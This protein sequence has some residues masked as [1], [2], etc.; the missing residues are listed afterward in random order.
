MLRHQCPKFYKHALLLVILWLAC[1][2][3]GSASVRIIKGTITDFDSHQ[4]VAAATVQLTGTGLA[5]VANDQGQYR[6][7]INS[8][9]GEL[10]VSHVAY[11]SERRPLKFVDSIT[12]LNFELHSAVIELS[13]QVVTPRNYNAAQRIILAAIKRKKE[14]LSNLQCYSVDS[15]TRLVAREMQKPDSIN[16]MFITET[17]ASTYFRKPNSP[18]QVIR[19]RRE[20]ANF[21][22]DLNTIA[23]GAL[24]SLSRDRIELEGN[25]IVTPT[26]EDALDH[27][28]FYLI[29]SVMRDN[30]RVFELEIEPRNQAEPLFVGK[31]SVI[32]STYDVVQLDAGINKGFRSVMIRDMRYCV[33]YAQVDSEN[34]M[35]V[36]VRNS[37]HLRPSLLIPM[38]LS[39]SLVASLYN[40]SVN[41]P[42]S[43]GI[44]DEYALKVE[45]DADK[46]DTIRWNS[47]QSIPLSMEEAT[48]Y[49]RI[50][51]ISHVPPSVPEYLL[52]G[53]LRVGIAAAIYGDIF[54]F[55]RVEGA[56]LGFGTTLTKEAKAADIR[57]KSGYAFAANRWEHEYGVS[58]RL[59]RRHKVWAGA[60]YS[61]QYVSRPTI[62]RI[63][64]GSGTL[65]ALLAKADP[66]DYYRV[67]GFKLS[68]RADIVRH[69]TVSAGYND[70]RERSAGTSTDYSFFNRQ[71]T[72]RANP[73]I[74]EGHFRSISAIITYD[75]R[76]LV[77]LKG[78]DAFD[79]AAPD[80]L[81]SAGVEYSAPSF[82]HSDF[83]FRRYY[84]SVSLS[85]RVLGLGTSSLFGYYGGSDGELPPQEYFRVPSATS[86]FASLRGFQT[87]DGSGF[88]GSR[89]M[90]ITLRHE[91]GR[92]LWTKSG[93]PIV[94]LIPFTIDVYG[95]AFWT[96]FQGNPVHA[97]D[98]DIRV[99]R[100]AYGEVGFAIGNLTPFMSPFNLAIGFTWQVSGYSTSRF[101]TQWGPRP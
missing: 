99:A 45:P 60:L 11:Y 90:A 57:V 55:N 58:Y 7:L 93:I 28:N 38:D 66:F 32:D 39:L 65:P 42:L 79:G 54:H 73:A 49:H 53:L 97:G 10:K 18:K 98:N 84:A 1:P 61:D 85:K 30:R 82:T 95:G 76:K 47:Y 46:A 74:I 44:I 34:W 23:M 71:D 8:D 48:A 96:D 67:K 51:S 101:E 88:G 3:S 69:T 22:V 31:M 40:I 5:T 72:L 59:W 91:F 24:L 16:V 19:I 50:D 87:V 6:L 26:G 17:L 64:G 52:A 33:R 14:F 75:S 100:S 81:F 9:S 83:N 20:T 4:P 29:D 21:P 89:V 56:Y 35:P 41:Q 63:W 37:F 13:G 92:L 2:Q 43:S 86:L 80:L 15:Y 25:E 62:F 78:R 94:K 27:Y 70:Y 36:E 68:A 12:V 77:D